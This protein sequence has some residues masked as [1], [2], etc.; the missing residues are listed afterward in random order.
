[1]PIHKTPE[2]LLNEKYVDDQTEFEKQLYR[3]FEESPDPMQLINILRRKLSIHDPENGARNVQILDSM[4]ERE[5]LRKF[6]LF[7][8][9]CYCSDEIFG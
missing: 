8:N 4:L 2:M 5:P 7:A 6:V 3:M 1:M 9:K